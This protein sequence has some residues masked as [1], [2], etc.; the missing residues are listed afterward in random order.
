MFDYEDS[1]HELG[2]DAPEDFSESPD[3]LFFYL[4]YDIDRNNGEPIFSYKI[5]PGARSQLISLSGRDQT[6]W[7]PF[8]F[9]G[10]LVKDLDIRIYG[11]TVV[12][13]IMEKTYNYQE[14]YW[15]KYRKA[16][17]T[18]R[19]HKEIYG[20]LLYEQVDGTWKKDNDGKRTKIQFKAKH[21]T[22]AAKSHKFSCNVRYLASDNF[23]EEHEIDPDIKNPST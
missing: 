21:A 9:A 19:D 17:K 14:F 23:L 7:S 6:Q 10:T 1:E 3:T 13:M 20:H 5:T 11:D 16:I 2:E 8:R 18:K 15:S 12:T 22:G 4:R